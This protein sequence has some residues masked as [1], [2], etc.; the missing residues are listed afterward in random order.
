MMLFLRALVDDSIYEFAFVW[1]MI[2][3]GIIWAGI[4]GT[5]E[6]IVR[7]NKGLALLYYLISIAYGAFMLYLMYM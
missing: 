1:G 5:R 2:I 3:L 4:I 6:L 7:S